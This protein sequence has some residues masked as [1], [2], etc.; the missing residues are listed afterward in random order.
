MRRSSGEAVL[1]EVPGLT[2][3]LVPT[4]VQYEPAKWLTRERG[5]D[6]C[7]SIVAF[8]AATCTVACL[9]SGIALDAPDIGVMHRLAT[10]DAITYATALRNEV[11]VITCD[12]HVRGLPGAVFVPKRPPVP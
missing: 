2:P 10:A 8:I 6:E 3:L 9:D 12:A 4:I 7:A 5:E 11:P 1:A